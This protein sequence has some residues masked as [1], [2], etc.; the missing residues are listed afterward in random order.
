MPVLRKL[1]VL[2]KTC[3]KDI[4]L[5]PNNSNKE[6]GFFSSFWPEKYKVRIEASCL[7]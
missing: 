2:R 5:L 6:N 1:W 4:D 7:V 3:F